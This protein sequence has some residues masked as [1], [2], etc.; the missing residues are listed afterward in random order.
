MAFPGEGGVGGGTGESGAVV[1]PPHQ[2]REG[3]TGDVP[4]GLHLGDEKGRE[5]KATRHI[6][7]KNKPLAFPT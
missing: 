4:A 1:F 6:T 3:S 5:D 2:Q 7:R